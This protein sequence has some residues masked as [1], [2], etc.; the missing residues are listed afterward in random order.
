MTTEKKHHDLFTTTRWTMVM[1]VGQTPTVD[2]CAA[3]EYLCGTY[4]LPLYAYVRGKGHQREDAEDLV[5]GFFTMLLKKSDFSSLDARHGKFRAFL[6]AS[7]KNYIVNDYK[8]GHRAKR[9]GE[10]I[11]L[12]LDWERGEQ[13]FEIMDES[14]VSPDEMYD[15]QWALSL[16]ERVLER[17]HTEWREKGMDGEFLIM[18]DFLTLNASAVRYKET[19]GKMGISEETLRVA[20]HRL[21]KRYRYLLKDEISQTLASPDMV[22]EELGALMQILSGGL[23]GRKS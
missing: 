14:S 17:L 4:W 16:L 18:R 11:K 23:S 6:L 9:G 20:V 15:R 2:A 21:R 7:L 19:S 3:L 12:S 5:Q 22:E 1:K 8:R 13:K 10:D